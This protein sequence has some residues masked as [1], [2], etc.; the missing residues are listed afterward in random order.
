MNFSFYKVAYRSI[1]RL[2]LPHNS[3]KQTTMN[4]REKYHR[5]LKSD[6]WKEIKQ[7]KLKKAKS[8]FVCKSRV[9][10]L[11]HHFSY[12]DIYKSTIKKASKNTVVICYQ[13]HEAVHEE[14]KK[15]KCS[16]EETRNILNR[17]KSDYK[18]AVEIYH[19]INQEYFDKNCG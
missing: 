13:C 3:R 6:W 18:K 9:G 1:N 15:L 12:K 8:C 11:L 17:M 16:Y 14:Q 10:L 2:L 4:T 5:Y 19:K 7:S